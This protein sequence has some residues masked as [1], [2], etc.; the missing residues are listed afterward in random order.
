[1]SGAQALADQGFVTFEACEPVA[2]WARA[3]HARAM[4]VTQDAGERAKWLRHGET[5]FVGVDAL[6]N[7]RQGAMDG[8]DLEGPWAGYIGNW[9]DWHAAQLSVVYPHYPL[10]DAQESDAAHG[11][12]KRRFA[13]HVDGL[14]PEGGKRYLREPHAFVLGIPLNTCAACPLV[15][16]PGSH[17][18]MGAALG[19]VLRAALEQAADPSQVDITAAYKAA[20]AQVFEQIEPVRIA[21]VPGQSSLLHRHLLHGVA[22]WQAGD[23]MPPEGRMAAY[24]RP[25]FPQLQDWLA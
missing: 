12:R 7:D 1:M 19:S 3:A 22:P 20:R 9:Q 17:K 23:E 24:F 13:A 8:Q 16:W 6:P 14:L 21:G 11:F 10:Q 25:Q 18:I 2:A 15:V 4:Q 5:W